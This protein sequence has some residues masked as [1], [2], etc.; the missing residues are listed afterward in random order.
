MHHSDIPAK[1]DEA[2]LVGGRVG[3]L[4][5]S[6][7]RNL[8]VELYTGKEYPTRRYPGISCDGSG[9]LSFLKK[10]L[11]AGY[12]LV[13]RGSDAYWG[14]PVCYV[15]R[16]D[17]VA[18]ARLEHA[19]GIEI[20]FYLV[21]FVGSV[22]FVCRISTDSQGNSASDPVSEKYRRGK[23]DPPWK[24]GYGSYSV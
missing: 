9:G 14:M 24:E 21:D 10:S 20:L 16:L 23:R 1:A 5:C 2:I 7:D 22:T 19:P 17:G 4:Q 13:R 8:C 12:L 6:F 11:A 15:S 3:G 18:G